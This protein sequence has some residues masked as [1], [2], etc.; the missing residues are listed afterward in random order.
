MRESSQQNPRNA[1]LDKVVA[2]FMYNRFSSRG[3]GGRATQA[4]SGSHLDSAGYF[5]RSCSSPEMNHSMAH[6]GLDMDP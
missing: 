4:F 3:L 6:Q 1:Y 5:N 2:N